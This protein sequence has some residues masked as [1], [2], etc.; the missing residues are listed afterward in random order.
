MRKKG[1]YILQ[2]LLNG[3]HKEIN[4]EV[5]LKQIDGPLKPRQNIWEGSAVLN[6]KEYE[7]PDL[8]YCVNA[9]YMAEEIGL[10]EKNKLRKE[11]GRKLRIKKEIIK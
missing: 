11:F 4:V 1:T 7:H 6:D 8:K 5:V 9:M 10:F 3:E 2:Y